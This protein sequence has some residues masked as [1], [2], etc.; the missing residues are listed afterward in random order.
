MY[1]EKYMDCAIKQ[2][3]LAAKKNEVPVGAV[4][5][6]KNKIIAKAHNTRQKKHRVIDHAEIKAILK[7]AKKLKDWRLNECDLYVTL[8]PCHMCETVIME[9]RIKNVYYLLEKNKTKKEYSKTKITQTNVCYDYLS[10]LSEF[11]ENKR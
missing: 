1:I 6:Y 4:I 5:V 9:S 7:A 2:A 3:V 11:F 10:I 8:K